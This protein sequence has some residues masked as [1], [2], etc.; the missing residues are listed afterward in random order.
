MARTLYRGCQRAES[1][2][3]D[4]MGH[5]GNI[6]ADA[7]L[8]M[9]T[10]RERLR[11]D[12]GSRSHFFCPLSRAELPHSFPRLQRPTT[13]D[14]G[15]DGS[16]KLDY[17]VDLLGQSEISAGSAQ[18]ALSLPKCFKCICNFHLTHR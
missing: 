6:G 7:P 13:T 14:E 11:W 18:L 3:S 12:K 4:A 16:L 17:L 2:V 15:E 1:V 10:R 9:S 5:E 8:W